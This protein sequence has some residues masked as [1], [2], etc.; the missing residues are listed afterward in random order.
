MNKPSELKPDSNAMFIRV[1]DR[2]TNTCSRTDLHFKYLPNSKYLRTKADQ[3]N[4]KKSSSSSNHN[5]SSSNK[6]NGSHHQNEHNNNGHK[7]S[8]STNKSSSSNS[9]H[10]NQNHPS[11]KHS[12]NSNSNHS[13]NNSNNS[14]NNNPY[15]QFPPV[16]PHLMD[17]SKILPHLL[18]FLNMPGQ[19]GVNPNNP[20]GRMPNN[21]EL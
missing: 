7:Q 10:N 6:N 1:W 14:N 13:T 21:Q 12:N 20:Q 17:P 9:E 8:S 5:N 11:N 4:A 16:N 2:G 3:S 19:Q 18:P 15:P